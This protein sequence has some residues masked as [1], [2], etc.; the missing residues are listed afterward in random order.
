[1]STLLLTTIN[2][3]GADSDNV[4]AVSGRGGHDE[5]ASKGTMRTLY[6]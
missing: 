5:D 6:A 3:A 4:A 1:M 2:S